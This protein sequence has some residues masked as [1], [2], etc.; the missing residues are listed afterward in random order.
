MGETPPALRYAKGG[1][2][3]LQAGET[4]Y[5]NGVQVALFP[6]DILWCTQVSGPGQFSHCCGT[7]T[8]WV[9][10]YDHYPFYAPFDCDLVASNNS[11]N[12]RAYRSRT[13]VLTPSGTQYLITGFVHDDNPPVQTSFNQGELIGHTGITG[14]AT[15]DHVHLDQTIGSSYYYQASGIICGSGNQCY[16][17]PD[18]ID[19]TQAYYLTGN[20][21]IV[22]TLG[23]TFQTIDDIDTSRFNIIW[24]GGVILRRRRDQADGKRRKRGY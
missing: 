18:G 16:Y 8:D 9:G 23:Q 12:L 4:A 10:T 13:P 5:K 17:V 14:F 6:L 22:E 3:K 15:G 11:E 21:T 1:L 19:P 24:A 20:E 7:A 2:I